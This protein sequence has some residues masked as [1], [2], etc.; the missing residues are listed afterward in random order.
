M[1]PLLCRQIQL[2]CTKSS[3]RLVAIQK[4]AS[5]Q[6]KL[7][8][9]P[10]GIL[11]A[12][13]VLEFTIMGVAVIA[14]L[15]FPC[16]SSN[17]IVAARGAKTIWSPIGGGKN[18]PPGWKNALRQFGFGLIFCID[19][20]SLESVIPNSCR[21]QEARHAT[22]GACISSRRPGRASTWI[23]SSRT[24]FLRRIIYVVDLSFVRELAAPALRC[25]QGR[26]RLIRK[27]FSACSWSR[28]STGSRGTAA[29]V[30]KFATTGL[31]L[32]CGCRS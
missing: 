15:S 28:T 27:S 19:S 2:K 16:C 21:S 9:R 18:G 4:P 6:S 32:V 12:Q 23:R 14:E 3:N 8:F 29:F 31:P 22:G 10:C 17:T 7:H 24:S 11:L 30:R 5:T 20:D 25:Q 1:R 13:P 26:R